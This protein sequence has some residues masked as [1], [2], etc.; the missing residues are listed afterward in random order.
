MIQSYLNSDALLFLSKEESYGLPLVEAMFLGLPIICADRP[1]ARRLCGD[2]AIYFDPDSVDQ[3]KVAV[4]ELHSRLASGWKP[5][6]G[7]YISEIPPNWSMVSE[8]FI[9][10]VTRKV[11]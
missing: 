11:E 10:I 5:V 7:P 8:M 9:D 3:L 4:R 1:Y 2:Q 6:W